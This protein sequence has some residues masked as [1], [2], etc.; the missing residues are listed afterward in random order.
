VVDYVIG[1]LWN[2]LNSQT[3]LTQ[4]QPLM[5]GFFIPEAVFPS[6]VT[7]SGFGPGAG[8]AGISPVPITRGGITLERSV[9]GNVTVHVTDATEISAGV[10]RI[11]YRSEGN[12]TIAGAFIAAADEQPHT[13]HATIYSASVKHRFNENLMVYGS[14]GTSWR[15]GSATN[16]I[17]MRDQTAPSPLEASFVFPDAEKS[18]SFEIGFKSDWFDKRVRLNV[19]A[20]HQTFQNYAFSTP[21][22]YV[23]ATLAGGALAVRQYNPAIAV[24]VPAKVNGIEAEFGFVPVPR[25]TINGTLSYSKSKI[26]NGIIPCNDYFPNDGIPDSTNQVPASYAAIIAANGGETIATCAVNFR[27]GTAAPFIATVQ[28]EY[29]VPITPHLDGY[30]RGPLNFFGDSQNNPANAFDD[31]KAYAL[32]SLYAGIRD[33]DGSWEVAAFVKNIFDTERV[34]TRGV[35]P[36][37]VGYTQLNCVAQIPACGG[38]TVTFG[39]TAVSTYRG[40]TMTAPREIGITARFAFG[41]R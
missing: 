39:Q 9:F 33:P 13:E 2:R 28:S 15:P 24:G 35:G 12:L 31:I 19:T 27:A 26:K 30:V 6:R 20:Y 18:K 40:I 16:P 14:F 29:S 41:S 1:G 4:G 5:T 32:F 36:L 7:S 3:H 10:R 34:L 23:A 11:S 25:W 17:I 37:T 38:Q 8:F 21:G 22:V